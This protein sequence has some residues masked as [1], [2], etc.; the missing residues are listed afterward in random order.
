[1]RVSAGDLRAQRWWLE[2]DGW[3]IESMKDLRRVP[4]TGAVIV[5]TW[6]VPEVASGFP[7]RTAAVLPVSP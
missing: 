6:P 1:M 2:H 7:A 4:P 3:M 5:A